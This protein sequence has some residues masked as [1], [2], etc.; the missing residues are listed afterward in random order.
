MPLRALRGDENVCAFEY[1]PAGWLLLKGN[2]RASSL[3]MPCCGTSAVP[4][5]SK[6]GNY[7]FAHA[8][9]GECKSAPESAEHIRLK[10]LIARAAATSGW[11]VSTEQPGATPTGKRW[12]ADVF[13]ERRNGRV[14]LEAQLSRL[15][16]AEL[17]A[18][19]SAYVESGVR[20]AWFLGGSAVDVMRTPP[21]E[22]FPCFRVSDISAETEPI[23]REFNVSISEF[24]SGMLARRLTWLSRKNILR[25]YAVRCVCRRCRLEIKNLFAYEEAGNVIWGK[26]AANMSSVLKSIYTRITRRFGRDPYLHFRDRGLNAIFERIG[27]EGNREGFDFCNTCINCSTAHSNQQLVEVLRD[28]QITGANFSANSAAVEAVEVDLTPGYVGNWHFD[29]REAVNHWTRC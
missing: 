5:T 14:A 11:T 13:C 6:L 26:N 28:N 17:Q 25:A 10:T 20:A 7:F 8:R 19:Q 27:V 16:S 4:K 1:D 18:R 9:R 23:I 15:S 2:Y 3:R 22:D 12:I 29:G 24:V 21:A